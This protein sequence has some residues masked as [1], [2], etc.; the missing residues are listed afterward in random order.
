MSNSKRSDQKTAVIPKVDTIAAI[1]APTG[2]VKNVAITW[3][4]VLFL[5]NSG[6]ACDDTFSIR[7]EGRLVDIPQKI[8]LSARR[9]RL[10]DKQRERRIP[11][12]T[13][14]ILNQCG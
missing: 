4:V 14:V 13:T 9:S 1:K 5:S 2:G 12:A 10:E 7:G 6:I 11:C 3:A 8:W